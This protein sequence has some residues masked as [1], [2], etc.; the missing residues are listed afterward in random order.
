[1]ARAFHTPIRAVDR[2][3]FHAPSSASAAVFTPSV[4]A[5][6]HAAAA[7]KHLL[8]PLPADIYIIEHIY[9]SLCFS[10]FIAALSAATYHAARRRDEHIRCDV[11]RE[12]VQIRLTMPPRCYVVGSRLL[13]RTIARYAAITRRATTCYSRLIFRPDEMGGRHDAATI[14][15][16]YSVAAT[17]R[18]KEDI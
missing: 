3:A 4:T 18:V 1:M 14:C 6:A 16:H 11:T 12:A 17:L 13:A 10:A 2:K 9:T 5:T 8:R 7:A 15:F